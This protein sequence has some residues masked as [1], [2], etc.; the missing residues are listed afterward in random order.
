MAIDP[1][2]L[3]VLIIYGAGLVIT[4]LVYPFLNKPAAGKYDED[5]LSAL[6]GCAAMW[7]IVWFFVVGYWTVVGI[8]I[9]IRR[10]SRAVHEMQE[11]IAAR[12]KGK[13][14]KPVYRHP[15]IAQGANILDLNEVEFNHV[16]TCSHCGDK[17]KWN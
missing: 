16:V 8:S 4:F 17:V 2:P 9:P 6:F 12:S 15:T 5:Y 3:T 7:P 13:L 10:Y 1:T 14:T 11:S